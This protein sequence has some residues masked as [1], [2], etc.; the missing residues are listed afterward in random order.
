MT[1]TPKNI[2]LMIVLLGSILDDRGSSD[3]PG[4]D[5]CRI[6]FRAGQCLCAMR[7]ALYRIATTNRQNK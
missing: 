4:S 2:Y 1:L 3:Q 7:G 6:A 5:R